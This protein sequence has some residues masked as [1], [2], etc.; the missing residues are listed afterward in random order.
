M[1]DWLRKLLGK[2]MPT[3]PLESK[4]GDPMKVIIGEDMEGGQIK[5]AQRGLKLL[6]RLEFTEDLLGQA[7]IERDEARAACLKLVRTTELQSQM[8]QEYI[9][10][11]ISREELR[12]EELENLENNGHE[13]ASC[14][15]CGSRYD[16]TQKMRDS[17]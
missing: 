1:T 17:T 5:K 10:A 14:H 13:W 16:V 8:I 12:E 2:E 15:E 3:S 7:I 6:R 4:L 11:D 9:A